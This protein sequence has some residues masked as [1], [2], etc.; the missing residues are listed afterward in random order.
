MAEGDGPKA[1]A[2]LLTKDIWLMLCGEDGLQPPAGL[3]AAWRC[4]KPRALALSAELIR[5]KGL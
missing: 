5:S 1:I 2:S 4:V 3:S